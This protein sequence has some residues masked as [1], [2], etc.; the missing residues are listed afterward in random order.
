MDFLE[1]SNKRFSTRKFSSRKIE[2]E[3]INKIMETARNAPTAKNKQPQFV[4]IIKSEEGL[5]KINKV[6]PCIYG[7]PVVFLVCVNLDEVC[8]LELDDK[9]TTDIDGTIVTTQ[10]MLEATD[11]G[12]GSV[13]IRYFKKEDVKKELGLPD[14]LEPVLILPVGYTADDYVINPNHTK[15]K[16]ISEISKEI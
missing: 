13:M 7:A 14:N 2:E 12:L 6:C 15:R 3:K 1:L 9:K 16:D 10:M 4:Y 11:L 5:Q 8:Y